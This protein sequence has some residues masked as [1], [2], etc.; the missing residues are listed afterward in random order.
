MAMRNRIL[1]SRLDR[2]TNKSDFLVLQVI[3]SY[4]STTLLSLQVVGEKVP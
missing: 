1:K 3:L 4:T 2:D